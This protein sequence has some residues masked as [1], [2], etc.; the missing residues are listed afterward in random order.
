MEGVVLYNMVKN[1]SLLSANAY[2]ILVP[3]LIYV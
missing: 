2:V 1:T 3:E